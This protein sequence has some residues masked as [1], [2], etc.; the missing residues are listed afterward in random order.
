MKLPSAGQATLVI[1]LG[2]KLGSI[3]LKLLKGLKLTKVGLVAASAAG[4]AWLYTWQFSA[5]LLF[6]LIVHESGHVWAMKVVGI[7]TKGFYLIPFVGGAAVPEREFKSRGEEYFVAIM[8][9]IFGVASAAV[10]LAVGWLTGYSLFEAVAAFIAMINLFN[11]LPITP[12]DGGRIT[13]S[14]AFSAGNK[15]GLYWII[16]GLVGCGL[17]IMLA[18]VWLLGFILIIGCVDLFFEWKRR[19]QTIPVIP[20]APPAILGYFWV[21]ITLIMILFLGSGSPEGQLALNALRG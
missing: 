11:L 10:P 20:S 12:L 19:D 3:G 7:P 15:S 21:C 8:G 2:P 6:A 14:I 18:Q 1:K 16:A 17:I 4:Y 13:K 9:P 5:I